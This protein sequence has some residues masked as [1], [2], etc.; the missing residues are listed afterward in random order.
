VTTSIT[1]QI[2]PEEEQITELEAEN[3]RLTL[4]QPS[5]SRRQLEI[6]LHEAEAALAERERMLDDAIDIF[7]P[8]HTEPEGHEYLMAHLRA[9]A[10]EGSGDE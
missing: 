1:R 5:Y 7:G 3:L 10:E 6:R 9:R 8:K 4:A 2:S